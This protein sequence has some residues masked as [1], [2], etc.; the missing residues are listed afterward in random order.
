M[1]RAEQRHQIDAWMLVQP[2]RRPGQLRIDAAHAGDETNA[3]PG[4]QIEP[5]RK[6]NFKAKRGRH[7][8]LAVDSRTIN[9]GGRRICIVSDGGPLSTW[10]SNLMACDAISTK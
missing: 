5:L 7:G 1:F 3:P 9:S 8:N 6:Q 4:N 2:L 10:S